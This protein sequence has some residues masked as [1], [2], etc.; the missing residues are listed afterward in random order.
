[1]RVVL[2]LPNAVLMGQMV[3]R[4]SVF[5]TTSLRLGGLW[6]IHT[7]T[8][9]GNTYVYGAGFIDNGLSGFRLDADGSF[10]NVVN[11]GDTSALTLSGANGLASAVVGGRTFLYANGYSDN[12]VTAF[13]VAANGSLTTVQTV[14]DTAALAL[15]NPSTRMSVTTVNDTSFLI[16][17]GVADNGMSVF[18]IGTDG[19]LTN[20]ASVFDASNPA[21]ALGG[22]YGTAT[23][24]VGGRNFVV[25]AAG[26]E[27]GL[28]VFEL[29]AN[30][31]LTF[32]DSVFDSQNS[33][34]R[35]SGSYDVTTATVNGSTYM[36]AAGGSED[37]LSVFRV[38]NDG[39]LTNAYNLS[40]LP[41]YL[42]GVTGLSTFSKARPSLRPRAT[43]A[44]PWAFCIS[45]PTAS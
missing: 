3:A 36:I 6:D 43:R 23:A 21:F 20:T 18:R 13:E 4:Q 12:G 2:L 22:A 34:Y 32:R 38:G 8:A 39:K 37:G 42:S 17:T 45:P 30:G 10:T 28:S 27:N 5:D 11:V 19:T 24:E 44:T 14:T 35:I 40:S 33:A 31:S 16:A 15:A 41:G 9:G 25:V 1:M 26:K 7:L 29:G